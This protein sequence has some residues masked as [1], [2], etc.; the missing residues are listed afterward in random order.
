MLQHKKLVVVA[1][2]HVIGLQTTASP[3]HAAVVFVSSTQFTSAEPLNLVIECLDSDMPTPWLP[4]APFQEA[5][6]S[7]GRKSTSRGLRRLKAR[8]LCPAE[9]SRIHVSVHLKIK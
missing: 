3:D 8:A 2:G 9:A 6:H 7:D 1:Q 4:G 5:E